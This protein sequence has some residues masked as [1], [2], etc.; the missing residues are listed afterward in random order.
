MVSAAAISMANGE[1]RKWRKESSENE[2]EWRRKS[3]AASKR[4]GE[5]KAYQ[6]RENVMK[7]IG[8]KRENIGEIGV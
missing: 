6:R 4:N 1:M 2:N 3:V 8:R 5:M 7:S